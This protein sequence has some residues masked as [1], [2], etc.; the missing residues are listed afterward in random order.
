MRAVVIGLASQPMVASDF[1]CS[2]IASRAAPSFLPRASNADL[3]PSSTNRFTISVSAG[4]E[5]SPSPAIERSTS[6]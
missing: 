1:V 5:A 3:R 4:S 2:T 6:W